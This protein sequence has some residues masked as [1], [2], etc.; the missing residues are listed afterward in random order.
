MIR[1]FL[2]SIIFFTISCS[3]DNK[4]GIWTNNE[5]LEASSEKVEN[6]FEKNEVIKE[7]LNSNYK[8]NT[9][10]SF[11]DN[12]IIN[13]FNN[14]GAL[15]LDLNF[16]KIS[17][18]KFSKINNFEYFDPSLVFKGDDLIFFDKKGSI[19]RFDDSS[20]VIWKKNY[21]SKS[22][23]K[24]LP[25]L[26][27]SI[28]NEILVVTD[29][30][31][32]FYSLNTETG[33]LIWSKNHNSIFISDI[34]IDGNQFYII[35]SNNNFHCFSLIDGSKI[36]EFNTDYELI[37]SQKKLSIAFDKTNVYFNNS[38]GDLYSLDKINGNL[39]WITPTRNTDEFFKSFLLKSS[40]IVLDNNNLYFSNNQNTFFSINKKSGYINWVQNIN[41][42]I[43]PVIV[44]G[45]I[46]TITNDGLLFIL[47]KVSGNIIRIT[48]I[49][50][51]FKKRKIK[52]IKPIGFILDLNNVYLSLNNG[53]LLKI[54]IENG[55]TKSIFKIS[56]DKIS[57]PFIN[58]DYMFIVKDNEIIKLN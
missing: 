56:R 53:R 31:S 12:N 7:E 37:K 10:I 40:E 1:F 30:L 25:I 45:L 3:F 33:E 49:Y 54:D 36:W 47:E 4:S 34:K 13:G 41:S 18:Y 29:S 11:S 17:R 35:D 16:K 32:K 48:N 8:I 52:K 57:K 22:E 6:L 26:N 21:Y 15:K 55:K 46:F 14:H 27:F 39:I 50:N 5:I 24:I 44:K 43:K 19:I 28:Q 23:K 9:P 42:D 20:K 38:K 51:Q 58:Q 2:V